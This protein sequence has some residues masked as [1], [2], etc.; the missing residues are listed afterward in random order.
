[1]GSTKGS[2]P[3]A[4]MGVGDGDRAVSASGALAVEARGMRGGRDA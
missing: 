3:A 4:G 1:M 2:A